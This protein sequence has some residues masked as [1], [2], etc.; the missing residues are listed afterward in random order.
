MKPKVVVIVVIWNGVHDTV[1]CLQ[2][3]IQEGYPNLEILIIDNGSSD[4]SVS[5]LR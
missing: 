5:I 1:E 2:S 3:L 4:N